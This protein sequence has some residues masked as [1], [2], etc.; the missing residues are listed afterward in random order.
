[1]EKKFKNVDQSLKNL[2]TKI[3]NKKIKNKKY[4]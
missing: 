3:I 4:I 2:E 1:M